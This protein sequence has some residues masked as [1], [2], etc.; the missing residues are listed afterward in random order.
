[1][2][3]NDREE[4][5]AERCALLAGALWD[6]KALGCSTAW[7]GLHGPG[8]QFR[9]CAACPRAAR[10]RRCTW[11]GRTKIL[12]ME[13]T[14]LHKGERR[15]WQ[16]LGP[17]DLARDRTS[18]STETA[19]WRQLQSTAAGSG[20]TEGVRLPLGGL[21]AQRP[22]TGIFEGL[23]RY[24]QDPARRH[25]RRRGRVCPLLVRTAPASP[26]DQDPVR[27][28]TADN[29]PDCT[30]AGRSTG[31][32]SMMAWDMTVYREPQRRSASS[33]PETSSWAGRSS[34]RAD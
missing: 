3:P 33:H 27:A 8:Q 30:R 28:V 1:M 31:S 34:A 18:A 9:G 19:P 14:D 21:A 29:G 24:V 23:R 15:N 17:T 22:M 12:L 2:V 6:A 25:D 13:A 10:Q 4:V 11:L 16:L 32:T 20:L 5:S 26:P 7:A